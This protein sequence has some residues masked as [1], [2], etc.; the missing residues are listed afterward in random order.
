MPNHFPEH[1]PAKEKMLRTVIWQ[2]FCGDWSKSEKLSEIKPPLE[3]NYTVQGNLEI[4]DV[5]K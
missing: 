1:Y 2:L 3:K 4:L 5:V